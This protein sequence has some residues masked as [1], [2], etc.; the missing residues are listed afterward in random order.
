MNPLSQDGINGVD[1]DE[2]TYYG[3]SNT[4]SKII[5]EIGTV[6]KVKAQELLDSVKDKKVKKIEKRGKK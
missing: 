4:P 5:K 1:V 3:L 6:S 2:D